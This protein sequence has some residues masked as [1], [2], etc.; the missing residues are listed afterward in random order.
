M[1]ISQDKIAARED[2]REC[3][4]QFGEQEHTAPELTLSAD[5]E[6]TTGETRA[7]PLRNDES[8]WYESTIDL[9]VALAEK[10]NVHGTVTRVTLPESVGDPAARYVASL[11]SAHTDVGRPF[12]YDTG[13]QYF[14]RTTPTVSEVLAEAAVQAN[15]E[16]G[17]VSASGDQTAMDRLIDVL[18]EEDAR[19]LLAKEYVANGAPEYHRYVIRTTD[20]RLR[21]FTAQTHSEALREFES[22]HPDEE[23]DAWEDI[24]GGT[25]PVHAAPKRPRASEAAEAAAAGHVLEDT[26][27]VSHP[28]YQTTTGL[29]LHNAMSLAGTLGDYLAKVEDVQVVNE[30]NGRRVP[31]SPTAGL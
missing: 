26:Y 23:F 28:A 1:T 27:T 8:P 21:T 18:G 7:M 30:R 9:A 6:M 17:R 14:E 19:E 2:A 25:G 29:T 20:G 13:D 10:H 3:N 22:W 11:R 16:G 24:P 5:G 15:N 4:G 31:Y 12:V